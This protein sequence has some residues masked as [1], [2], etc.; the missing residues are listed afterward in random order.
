[1]L[2]SEALMPDW[3]AKSPDLNPIEQIWAFIQRRLR[4]QQFVGEGNLFHAIEAK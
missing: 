3:P 1:M 2:R 4:R